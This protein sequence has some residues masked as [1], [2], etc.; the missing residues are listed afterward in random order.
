MTDNQTLKLYRYGSPVLKKRAEAVT[1]FDDELRDFVSRMA[2]TLY[3][4]NGVGL[5]A[6]Q[7][8][9]SRRIVV[10]DLSFGEEVDRILP[11]INPEILSSEGECT[12]EEGCL[13]IPGIYEDVVRA[14]RIY[15]RYSDPEGRPREMDA[16][17]YLARV[18]Q[19]ESDHLDG[20]L[21]VDRLGAVKR[22][23]LAK[24][25]REIADAENGE[26]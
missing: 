18:I 9:V 8:G 6:P 22:T 5:A 2:N 14:E 25:L 24:A 26:A 19:H 12:L 7:V 4:E 17:G 13:S 10:I 3:E 23:F 11:M 15:V 21:F 20:I 1:E 16:E